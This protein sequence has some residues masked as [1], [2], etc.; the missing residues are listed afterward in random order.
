MLIPNYF[1]IN[2]SQKMA[3]FMNTFHIDR[4]FEQIAKKAKTTS[5]SV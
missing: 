2:N 1:L 5:F 3:Y 4:F